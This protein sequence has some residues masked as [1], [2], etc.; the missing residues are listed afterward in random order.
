MPQTIG[1]APRTIGEAP[2]TIG[3]APRTI[4][5]SLYSYRSAIIG[6]I[7]VARSAGR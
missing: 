1:E 3:E 2:R 7:L 4:G 6:S 5:R